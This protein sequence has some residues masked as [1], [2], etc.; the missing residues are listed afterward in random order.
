[1]SRS[2]LQVHSLRQLLVDHIKYSLTVET[3]LDYVVTAHS[4]SDTSLLDACLTFIKKPDNRY[5]ASTFHFPP[6]VVYRHVDSTMGVWVM[7][8]NCIR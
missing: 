6:V 2:F 7:S 8:M 4:V 1:M 3:V 5:K